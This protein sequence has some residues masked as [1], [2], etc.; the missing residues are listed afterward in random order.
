[1]ILVAVDGWIDSSYFFVWPIALFVS[2]SESIPAYGGAMALAGVVGGASGLLLGRHIDAGHGRWVVVIAYTVV[3]LVVLLRAASVRSPWLAVST[4]TRG[5]LVMPLLLPPLWGCDLQSRQS[6][7]LSLPLPHGDRRK[8]VRGLLFR[9]LHRG[10]N[11]RVRGIA[12]ACH[13]LVATWNRRGYRLALVLLLKLRC[14]DLVI[15]EH[16]HQAIVHSLL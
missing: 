1:M 9:L 6:L 7:T 4:N 11:L 15:T 10:D 3:A 5:A 14:S 2:L 13:P 12:I 8:L 16:A